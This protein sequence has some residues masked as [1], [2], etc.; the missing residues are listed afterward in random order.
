M[1]NNI[2]KILITGG[3]GFIGSNFI[4]NQIKN[5]H[6]LN[7]DKLT[8]AA[9]KA[10]LS[11]YSQNQNYHFVNGDIADYNKLIEVINNFKPESIINFA[12]ESH[13]DRS[14]DGPKDFIN[15]NIL[16]TYQLLEASLKYY[17]TLKNDLKKNFKL[18]HISTD[19]VYGS[20]GQNGTFNEKSPY[21]PSSPYSASKASSDCLVKAWNRTFGLPTLITHCSNNYGPFQ[22]PEKLIPLMII[23]C[24][25]NKELPIYGNGKNVRDWL[26]VE[27][28]CNAINCVL[29]KGEIGETYNIGGNNEHT[30][31]EIVNTICQILDK[32]FPSKYASSYKDLIVF[33]DDRPGHD[34]R[35]AIDSSK[36]RNELNWKSEY[37]FEEAIQKTIDWYLNNKGWWESILNKKYS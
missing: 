8:Y 17:N 37:T 6:I 14:I 3:C 15:T 20:L 11:K 5:N 9:N 2:K 21:N 34:F 36:I 25:N 31:N 13:V 16:G 35:Y 4:I 12:A 24:L 30:N 29:Q 23:N 7:F 19:E 28:H 18:L 32:K 27:D 10:N 26:Y 22:F 1:E 33:V